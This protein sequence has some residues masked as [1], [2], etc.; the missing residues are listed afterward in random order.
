MKQNK[1]T[2][3]SKN[4]LHKILVEWNDTAADY[5]T[6]QCLHQLFE[7]QAAKYPDNIAVQYEGSALTY[8]EM[9][10][11]ANQLAHYLQSQGV[12]PET[13]VGLFMERSLEMII[14]IYG[15]LKAGGAYVPLDPEYPA[16]RLAYIIAET[17]PPLLLTQAHLSQKLSKND[18]KMICLDAQWE[19]IAKEESVNLDSGV[20]PEN[21]IYVIYTSGSTGKPKGVMNTHRGVY[22]RIYWMKDSY[23]PN[24]SDRFLQ[25]TPFSFDASITEL[26]LPF[27]VGAELLVARPQGQKDSAYLIGL[28]R[29]KK[30]TTLDCVP[31]LL[32]ILL[33]ERDIAAC[34]SIK[35]VFCGGEALPS[36]LQNKFFEVLPASSLYNL[37]GPTEAA[38]DVIH[39]ACVQDSDHQ[40]VPIGTPIANTQIYILDAQLNPVPIG[41][42]GE[43]HIGG[44]QVARGY[45]NRSD[46]TAE[47]FILDPFSDQDGARLY[48]TGDLAR[49]LPDGTIEFL[50]RMDH[51]VKI[52]GFRIELGEIEIVLGGHPDVQQAEVIA[53]EYAAGDESLIAFFSADR[54]DENLA[55]ELRFYLKKKLPVYMIPSDFIL[56]DE[57]PRLPNGKTDRK[58]L[59]STIQSRRLTE[60]YVDPFTRVEKILAEMWRKILH[61]DRVGIR[62]NFFNLGGHSLLATQLISRI[63]DQYKVN[64]TMAD[65]YSSGT[66]EKLAKKI[67]RTPKTSGDDHIPSITRVPRSGDEPVSFPQERVVFISTLSPDSLAYNTQAK[68]HFTGELNMDAL[69]HALNEIVERHEIY[70]TT[71]HIVDGHVRQRVHPPWQVQVPVSD[72]LS[73]PESQ[74][75]AYCDKVIDAEIKQTFTID[76][77]PLI[78]WLLYKLGPTD[79]ILLLTEHHLVHDGISFGLFISELKTLYTIFCNHKA[80]PLEVPTIQFVDFAS[81]QRQWFKSARLQP[82]L[83]FWKKQ[84]E[85]PLPQLELPT[86]NPRPT[87]QSFQGTEVELILSPRLSNALRELNRKENSTLFITMLTAFYALL[88]HYTHQEDI[89]VGTGIANRRFKEI[90]NLIGMIVNTLALRIRFSASQTFKQLLDE[91]KKTVFD[92]D[93]H[94]D[95]PFEKLVEELRLERD[96]SR[97]PVFQVLFAFHDGQVPELRLPGLNGKV[98]YLHNGSAKFDINVIVIPWAEQLAGLDAVDVEQSILVKWEYATDIFKKSTIQRMKEHYRNILEEIVSNV[99]MQVGQLNLMRESERRQLLVEWNSTATDYPNNKSVHQLFEIC[100]TQHPNNIAVVYEENYLTYAALNSKANQ[101][102]HHLIQQGVGPDIL[103]GICMEHSLELIVGIL[104]ILKAGGA[105]MPIDPSYPAERQT[106]MIEDSQMAVL[107]TQ[108]TITIHL[109]KNKPNV[110]CIDQDWEKIET[111]SIRNPDITTMP[112]S[113]IYINYTS[114]STGRPKGVAIP[115]RAVTRLIFGI[116]CV[117][118]DEKRKILHMAPISFDASTFEIWGALLHGGQCVLCPVSLPTPGEIQKILQQY[119]I[120]TLWLTAAF[121]NLIID[122][123]PEALAGVKQLITGGEALSIPHVRKALTALPNTQIINGYGP[124][125]STTFAT[126]YPIPKTLDNAIASI[127]IGRP[128]GNTQCYILNELLRPVPIGVT[129]E[130]YIGGSGLARGY[131][132]RPELTAEKFIPNPFSSKSTSYLYKTGDMVRFLADGNI[133]FL[134]RMDHQI[135]IRGF[136]VELGEIES[137]LKQHSTVRDAVVLMREDK[138]G[139]KRLVAYIV[140]DQE[141]IPSPHD[142][143]IFIKEKVPGYMVPAAFVPMDAL[144]L[145]PNGKLDRNTLIKPDWSQQSTNTYL[146]PRTPLEEELSEIWRDLFQIERVGIH[147]NFFEIGGHSLLALQLLSRLRSF[148]QVEIPLKTLFEAPTIAEL[149]LQIIKITAQQ[150]DD[151]FLSLLESVEGLTEEEALSKIDN[152]SGRHNK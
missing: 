113:L 6:D 132:N 146:A 88:C 36:S 89:I 7:D 48:K 137:V 15:V 32:R 141:D 62:N 13:L 94:Q 50:G 11:R 18:S 105:Y 117:T 29:S 92:A 128:I 70:R 51:Q 41:T 84:L 124:T 34:Q 71:F 25:T 107:L 16:D 72:L 12:G 74:R 150:T 21:L 1:G 33:E 123:K 120:D 46:L 133:E 85:S 140:Y 147:S 26:F 68:I 22:N 64:L 126:C 65:L 73:Y 24:S 30:I 35:R 125:E 144:P 131:L 28:I 86:D 61:I 148:F 14:A 17:Q 93:A 69:N 112:E 37:Y 52:R 76:K 152:K 66:I 135:K 44:I 60:N 57:M 119:K 130:L 2:S 104:G 23:G 129:G 54:Q 138:P 77:L 96:L 118:L 56:L 59:N 49:Y 99:E 110:I 20:T 90:E 145:T 53:Y 121:F 108:K 136:R 45:L 43:L 9:N 42:S 47:R 38:V 31:S 82:L 39:W 142:L 78:R 101:M 151:D 97:N 100:V 91:V 87:R 115:H 58:A 134:R 19:I 149:S 5:P 127:P 83:T 116:D 27:A 8:S 4:D 10:H 95:L 75:A 109:P 111:E 122:E 67:E 139:D 98:E 106:F 81:W 102:A 79:H 143:N 3:L 114:G 103:V 80:S 55:E 40:K 63:R